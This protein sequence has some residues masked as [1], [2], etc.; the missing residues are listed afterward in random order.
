MVLRSRT[1]PLTGDR[2]HRALSISMSMSLGMLVVCFAS[3]SLVAQSSPG[4]I[5]SHP[6]LVN[7]PSVIDAAGNTYTTTTTTYPGLMVTP[8]AAQTQFG[9]ATEGCGFL[10][11]PIPCTDAYIAKVDA[12]G[13]VVFA[14]Y[15]GGSDLM[16]QP[17]LVQIRFGGPGWIAPACIT[18]A[19]LSSATL[20]ATRIA[21]GQLVTL[22]GFGIGP[23]SGVS[24]PLNAQEIPTALAGVQVL[25]D[26]K[27]AP[28]LYAQSTQVNFQAPFELSGQSTTTVTLVYNGAP[29][30]PVTM[31][32]TL[33]S[34]G[35]FRLQPNVS[36]LAHAV[37]QDGTLNGPSNPAGRG[38]VVSLWGTGFGPTSPACE[39]AWAGQSCS[40]SDG[41]FL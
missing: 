19:V 10:K 7:G 2:R 15:L 4:S 30:G 11:F 6:L 22:I 9:G 28:V 3:A 34:P 17:V 41:E 37:N 40:G 31:P 35:L 24:V 18:G 26:G 13:R 29:F 27:P 23:E 21:P 20:T 5:V 25:F 16:N 1:A 33:L 8:G 14:T 39:C 36:A 32:V 38:S 12:S